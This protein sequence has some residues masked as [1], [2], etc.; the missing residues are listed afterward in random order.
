MLYTPLLAP[1]W[2]SMAMVVRGKLTG[3]NSVIGANKWH[4]SRPRYQVSNLA[5]WINE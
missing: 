2:V 5:V 4:T 1:W 3:I